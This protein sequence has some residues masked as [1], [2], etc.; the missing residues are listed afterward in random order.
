MESALLALYEIRKT[1][2]N[3]FHFSPRLAENAEINDYNIRG[4]MHYWR[5]VQGGYTEVISLKNIF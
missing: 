1:F 3:I 5:G 2:W 4:L